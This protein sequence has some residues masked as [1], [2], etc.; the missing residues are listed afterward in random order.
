MSDSYSIIIPCYKGLEFLPNIFNQIHKQTKYPDEIIFINDGDEQINEEIL[1]DLNKNIIPLIYFKNTNNIGVSKSI[2]KAS[3]LIKTKY[4]KIMS[5]DD[6]FEKDYAKTH[7]DLLSMHPDAG[8][9]FS[10]PA[11]FYLEDN[12]Y[13]SYN[14]NIS[15]EKKFINN[16]EFIKIARTKTFKIF[17]N[18]PFY[19]TSIFKENN[20]FDDF[21]DKDADQLTNFIISAKYGACFV[22]D[23][24]TYWTMHSN[25]IS[26]FKFK[27][28]NT[29]DI[30]EN[31]YL[32]NIID[33]NILKKINFFY[34]TSFLEF[35]KIIFSKHFYIINLIYIK[36]FVKFKIWKIFR[37]FVPKIILAYI[38]KNF[39]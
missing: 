26:K 32:K 13:Y 36:K 25:Q 8:M 34:D 21:Y 3:K 38:V 28:H 33:Y 30:I 17:S 2:K 12:K 22:P 35:F 23:I 15:S 9:S 29:K 37:N 39:N 19:R 24:Q 27:K 31:I 1:Y 10:N 5:V 16:K 14:I 6:L 4:F 20:Y 7:L 18:T 11:F